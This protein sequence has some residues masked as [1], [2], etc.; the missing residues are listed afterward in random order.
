MPDRVDAKQALDNLIKI[1]RVHFYKPIQ[2]AE[3]LY[4]ARLYPDS[5][6]LARLEDY[7][8]ISKKWRDAISIE[9]VGNR[10]TSNSRYQDDLFNDN[11]IPPVIL[12]ELGKENIRTGGAVESYIYRQFVNRRSQL[13]QAL[14]YVLEATTE[15]FELKTFIDSFR[16]EAGLRRSI[17]KAFEVVVYA[18]FSTLVNALDLQVEISIDADKQNI[19]T[20][21][22][23]FA[24]K[25]MCLD[26]ENFVSNQSAR[27]FR[28][29]VANA[30]DRG[31]D[32]YSNWGPA[33]QI[34][35]LSLSEEKAEEIVNSVT[36]DRIV[37]VCKDAD[38]RLILSLLNQ[39][40]W[41]SRIQSIVT[42]SNL[43][44]WYKKALRGTYAEFLGEELLTCLC[45]EIVKEFP[46]L[47]EMPSILNDRNYENIIDGFWV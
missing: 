12:E 36:S 30:A 19:L 32:M 1:A 38:E 46:A 28:V 33:I 2:I 10:S 17:D 23:D 4:N 41:R 25:V 37:I 18:L 9:L 16:H 24:N 35:H 22:S 29:G 8:K 11:A 43:D 40:G 21:F 13:A 26:D 6:N 45:E 34:K 42:E 39:L 15:S 7:R 27:V 5:I 3:I 31:L 20:E 44:S 14:D 47:E